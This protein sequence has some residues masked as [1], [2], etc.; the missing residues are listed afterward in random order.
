MPLLV[1]DGGTC[2]YHCEDCQ[3]GLMLLW[4][5]MKLWDPWQVDEDEESDSR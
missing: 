3:E 4:I 5:V 1:K 2:P